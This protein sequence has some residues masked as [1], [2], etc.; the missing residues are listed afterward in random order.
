MAATFV[1]GGTFLPTEDNSP[2]NAT[3]DCTGA[4]FLVVRLRCYGADT[5]SGITFNGDALTL[6]NPSGWGGGSQQYVLTAP[7]QVSGTLA[8]SITDGYGRVIG[9]W[10]AWTGVTGT[11]SAFGASGTSALPASGS[12]TV[13]SGSAVSAM[14]WDNYAPAMSATAGTAV[15]TA[16]YDGGSGNR[17]WGAYRTSTGDLAFDTAPDSSYWEVIGLPLTG[18]GGGA[19]PVLSSPTGA[20]TGTSGQVQ[21]GVSVDTIAGV[22]LK[23]LQRLA[24]DPAASAA[25]IQST[26]VTR[27]LGGSAGVQ[28]PYTVTSLTDGVAYAWDWAANNGSDSSV[29]TSTATPS[30]GTPV[31][32]N[33]CFYGSVWGSQVV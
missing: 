27:A 24:S 13:A 26:G 1:R 9:E 30:A 20:A 2:R 32:G 18:A 12:K 10:E 28:G 4:D 21:I 31:S 19:A 15:G 33:A 11:G 5:I 6:N 3:I 22:T 29:V 23:S 25:T 7:D 17:A 14:V 16:S 8:M